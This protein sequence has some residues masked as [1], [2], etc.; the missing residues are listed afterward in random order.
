MYGAML[1]I[2]GVSIGIYVMTAVICI[3]TG[4]IARM[5]RQEPVRND[6]REPRQDSGE[7]WADIEWQWND[8]EEG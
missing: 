2:T 8:K 4:S 6:S 3:I 1:P 5:K 7:R